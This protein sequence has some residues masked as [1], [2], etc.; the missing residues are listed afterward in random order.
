M[1]TAYTPGLTVSAQTT[2]FKTRRLPIKGEVLVKEGDHVE[3]TTVVARA[4]LP[5]L[6]Q[7]VRVAH[8]LGIEP[9]E[10]PNVL[11]V[12]IGDPVEKDQILAETKGFLGLFRGVCKSPVKGTLELVSPETGNIGVREP[13]TIIDLHAYIRGVISQVMPDEGAIVETEG[14]LIQ[15]IFG[16]GGERQ[17]ALQVVVND[18]SEVLTAERLQ[19]DLNG[20]VIV[21]GSGIEGSAIQK[22]AEMGVTGIVVGGIR[23]VDLI[24]FLGRDIGVAIT[25]G[26]NIPLSIVATEGFGEIRMANRTFNLLKSLNGKVASLNGATQIR[27]GVIRPEII[28]P[29]DGEV[30]HHTAPPGAQMLDLDTPIRIIREP[31]FGKLGRVRALPPELVKIESGADVRVLE[32][33]LEDGQRVMVPRANVEIIAE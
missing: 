9:K 1:G 33:E 27:A 24:A 29:N 6:M 3:P 4:K 20:K 23:D 31:Y 14:A 16:V 8:I 17:G 13:P 15:G 2:V 22:A 11:Q 12:K 32:A 28:V 19:G 25:G 10:V 26:E 21:G 5:G 30:V 7:T 18:P